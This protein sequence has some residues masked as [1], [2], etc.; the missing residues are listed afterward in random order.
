MSLL[1]RIKILMPLTLAVGAACLLWTG[2]LLAAGCASTPAGVI[3]WWP[4][5]GDASDIIGTNNGTFFNA[6]FDT[7]EVGQAFNL[8]GTGNIL[9][10]ASPT[11]D[12]GQGNGI[13]IEAWINPSD[14]SSG[15][16]ILEWAQSGTYATHFWISGSVSGSLYANFFGLDNIS[17][18][19]ESAAGILTA[20]VYQHV[21]VTYDKASGIARL[22]LNGAVVKQATLGTFTPRT[23]PNL[24]IGYRPDTSPFGPIS[25]IGSIDE[26]TLYNR[27]LSTNELQAIYNAGAAGKCAAQNPL[28]SL[29]IALSSPNVTVAWPSSASNFALQ[30]TYGSVYPAE[31]WTNVGTNGI[32]INN[33]NV[34]TLPVDAPAKFFR[35]YHP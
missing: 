5:N 27:A 34:V 11:L 35:L 12:V 33:E 17:R 4:G 2:S 20:N 23:N 13:T 24:Y 21:G 32:V 18:P 1:K 26:V 10:P 8:D 14:L 31:T 6:Q 15:A 9:I 30:V 28:P 7:G 25:F 22:F 29:R 19:V 3:G 16:P